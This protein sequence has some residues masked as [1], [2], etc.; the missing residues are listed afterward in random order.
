MMTISANQTVMS[1]DFE[2]NILLRL[3]F[4]AAP[5]YNIS[6]ESNSNMTVKDTLV[7]VIIPVRNGERFV[8]RTLL[9]ALAQTY[10]PVEVVVVD[11]GST[12]QTPTLVETVAVHDNRVRLFRTR[13]FGVSAARNLGISRA[14]GELIAPLDADDLWHPEKIARQVRLMQ[15]A[16]PNVGLVYCWSLRIDEDDFLIWV[17]PV[18]H[19]P[20]AATSPPQ[21]RV[22]TELALT[23]FIANSSSP[24]IKRSCI[25]AVGGYDENVRYAEDWKLYLALADICEFAVIPEWLVGYRLWTGSA[26]SDVTAMAQSMKLLGRWL[27]EKWPDI[28]EALLREREYRSSVYLAQRALEQNQ[29]VKALRYW[30]AGC[31]V[32]PAALIERSSFVFGA[33]ILARMVGLRKS[34]LKGRGRA[35]RAPVSFQEFHATSSD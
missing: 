4:F 25:D 13:Q 27:I 32:R 31:T 6:G 19:G 28:P 8:R 18:K 7:S 30:T 21:G 15:S 16:S 20:A 33:R 29:F 22:I 2:C 34:A 12:D 10:D 14:R 24:L 11:D 1:G 17:P 23:N 5:R 9:S 3:R 35:F 26:S